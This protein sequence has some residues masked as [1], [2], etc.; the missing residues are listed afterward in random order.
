[1]S[2]ISGIQIVLYT[3]DGDT[4]ERIQPNGLAVVPGLVT[5]IDKAGLRCFKFNLALNT[6]QET[7]HPYTVFGDIDIHVGEVYE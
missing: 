2:F 3:L 7:S 4:A 1:M 6:W 5:Y